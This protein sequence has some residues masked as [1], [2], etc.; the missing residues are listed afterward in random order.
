[1][2]AMGNLSN[3]VIS[4]EQTPGLGLPVGDGG[5]FALGEGSHAEDSRDT[6]IGHG[7]TVN[8]DGSVAVGANSNIDVAATNAVAI[9]ADTNVTAASGTALGQAASVTA[10]GAVALGQGSVADQANTV[11]VGSASQHRRVTNVAAGTAATDAAN[12]GQMQAGD[13]QAVATA[14]AYTD[15][16]ATQTLTRANTYTDSRFQALSD[17]FS[18]LS[19]DIGMRLGEQDERID[20]QGAMSSA[21]M[22]MA[23]NAANSRSPRG[24]VA[25]G[26]G[27]QNGESALSV[28]YSKP[29]GERASFSIGGTFSSDD[30]SAGVGFGIDL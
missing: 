22:N 7:A 18:N 21:M 25:V 3:R 5:G 24:R 1:M 8:A 10:T 23:I 12:V 16:T 6:A 13:A 29:V 14:R 2:S 19:N 17:E 26:A 11:S 9:G 28:G 15:T 27:W 20:R 4:L 30:Q